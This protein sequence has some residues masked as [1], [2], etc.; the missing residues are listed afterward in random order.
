[1]HKTKTQRTSHGCTIHDLEFGDGLALVVLVRR[2]ACRLAADDGKLHVLDLDAHEQE[3][4]LAY[5]DI[6]QVISLAA[7]ISDVEER[8]GQIGYG[9][10][11]ALGF[12]VLE[13]N[14][15]TVLDTD[16]HLDGVI[17]VGWHAV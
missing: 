17:A 10:R 8:E 2:C 13:L 16:L 1:M 6:L 9:T 14:V 12:V 5:D 7:C 3:V 11:Y 15:K 4:D